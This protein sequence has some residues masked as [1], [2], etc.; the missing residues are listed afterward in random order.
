M[1]SRIPFSRVVRATRVA[2]R[3]FQSAPQ[4]T[5]STAAGKL[6][7]IL[8]SEIKHEQAEFKTPEIIT[9]FKTTG[10]EWT[11]EQD[12]GDVNLTLSKKQGTKKIT[13][14]WQLTSPFDN[15]HLGEEGEGEEFGPSTDFSIAVH[16]DKGHGLVFYCQTQKGDNHCFVIGNIK[17]YG[18]ENER[19]SPSSYNGPEFEDLE[20]SLRESFDEYLGELGVNE[21]L[22]NFIDATAEFK[23]QE[24]YMRWLKTVKTFCA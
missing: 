5:F 12:A 2:P 18:S 6:S 14:E 17:A 20:D 13:V 24:E 23:E 8:D 1:I 11:Y 9:N 10:K 22:C 19:D 7:T 21:T 4:R 15:E 16:D 3:V